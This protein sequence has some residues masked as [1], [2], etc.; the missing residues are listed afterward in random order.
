VAKDAGGLAGALDYIGALNVATKITTVIGLAALAVIVA[1]L[2]SSQWL[3]GRR[4]QISQ[5]IDK[6]DDQALAVLLGTMNVSLD[7]MSPAEK[8]ATAREESRRR[9]WQSFLFAGFLA[10]LLFVWALVQPKAAPAG[11]PIGIATMTRMLLFVPENE[12]QEMCAKTLGDAPCADI[13]QSI[14]GLSRQ[15]TPKVEQQIA[16]SLNQGTVSNGVAT[17]LR[18]LSPMTILTLGDPKGWDVAFRWCE[19]PEGDADRARATAA[20]RLL[21]QVP[22]DRIAAG[23]TLGR[24]SVLPSTTA[25][26]GLPYIAA[27]GSDG[28]KEAVKAVRNLLLSRGGGLYGASPRGDAGK[29]QINVYHCGA[30][31]PVLGPLRGPA[32]S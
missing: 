13:V 23:V 26:P 24:I 12:R 32:K 7:G 18:R 28:G 22:G 9:F 14:A 16:T 21:A 25:T 31:A 6:G 11:E 17:T 15:A 10:L 27:D 30:G 29:W 20:A 19:G 8:L 4:A 1:F 5:A 3:S 2:L